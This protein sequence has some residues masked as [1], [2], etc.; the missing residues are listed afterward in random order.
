M[1]LLLIFLMPVIQT[2]NHQCMP[3]IYQNQCLLQVHLCLIIPIPYLDPCDLWL[4]C[5]AP[6]CHL[7]ELL[8][9]IGLPWICLK[10]IRVNNMIFLG[11][12]NL[13]CSNKF[14]NSMILFHLD[15]TLHYNKVPLYQWKPMCQA[16]GVKN[17]V[18][19]FQT[20]PCAQN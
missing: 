3:I 7:V 15:G 20:P 2:H 10:Y 19:C 14:V 9:D 4:P 1:F 17:Y 5:Q 12:M 16:L 8:I 6:I 18:A 11:G 13:S